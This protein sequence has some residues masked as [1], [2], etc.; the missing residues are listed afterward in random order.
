MTNCTAEVVAG[1]DTYST[2]TSIKFLDNKGDVVKTYVVVVIG[3]INGDNSYDGVDAMQI[4]LNAAY[5]TDW[6]WGGTNEEFK[7]A[8]ADITNEGM[9]DSNDA[10]SIKKVAAY[11]GTINQEVS[12]Y[13]DS[14]FIAY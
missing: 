4:E 9:L 8:A 6:E 2:G 11:Q 5:V 10:N 13:G 7:A 1:G 3:D 12:P 14:S